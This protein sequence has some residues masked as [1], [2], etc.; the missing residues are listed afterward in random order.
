[1]DIFAVVAADRD[2]AEPD[3][4]RDWTLDFTGVVPRDLWLINKRSLEGFEQQEALHSYYGLTILLVGA[5]TPFAFTLL[6]FFP[7]L[8][9]LFARLRPY[10]VYPSTFG[11]RHVQPLPHGIG[12]APTMGQGMYIVFFVIL[13]VICSA[14]GHNSVQPNAFYKNTREEI[15][16]YVAN[17]TGV[18]AFALLPLVILFAGRNNF[19]LWITNWSHA[20]YLLFHRHVARIFMVHCIVHSIVEIELYRS[21]GLAVE[22]MRLS[23]WVWGVVGTVM[24]CALVVF[25]ARLFRRLTYEVFLVLHILMAILLLVGCWYHVELLFKRR[26]GY[27]FWLYAAFAVWIFDRAARLLRLAQT[28]P[29]RA[30]MQELGSSGVVRI[31]IPGVRWSLHPGHHAYI[32]WPGLSWWRTFGSHPFSVIPLSHCQH[33]DDEVESAI[34]APSTGSGR[35][36]PTLAVITDLEK[37]V[38]KI[39]SIPLHTRPLIRP[40]VRLYVK[41]HKGITSRLGSARNILTLLEG[42]Y[43]NHS[44]GVAPNAGV[45]ACDRLILLAGGIGITGVASWIRAHTNVKLY[46]SVRECGRALLEDVQ[47]SGLL[48]PL[49]RLGRLE[50]NVTGSGQRRRDL[51]DTIEHDVVDALHDSLVKGVK[52]GVI[53]CGSPEFCD[54]VRSGVVDIGRRVGGLVE[55]HYIEEAFGW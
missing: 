9:T 20:T 33:P 53:S 7:L 38:S 24:A 10:V 55:L 41:K 35:T 40:G 51:T 52:V 15:M 18:I 42:P 50:V 32:S 36:S 17:C 4:Q 8:P 25:S 26:W 2:N 29:L 47:Q 28:G 5:L 21:Q 43:R 6:L 16:L 14:V 34:T 3:H 54:S 22:Q 49:S 1:M 13:N 30:E 44:V 31:D 27:E 45:L 19:L 46:W 12:N 23:Y 48:E 39:R 11:G 37:A